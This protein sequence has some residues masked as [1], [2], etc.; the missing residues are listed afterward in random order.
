MF[1]ICRTTRDYEGPRVAPH[2]QAALDAALDE[3]EEL[4]IDA[5]KATKR[6]K[7]NTLNGGERSRSLFYMN[8]FVRDLIVLPYFF[9][10]QALHIANPSSQSLK[11]T[12]LSVVSQI[13]QTAPLGVHERVKRSRTLCTRLLED[14]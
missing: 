10:R 12:G 3:E 14:F 7:L 1:I 5:N 4:V 9:N 13:K 11:S 8:N 6:S 2:I